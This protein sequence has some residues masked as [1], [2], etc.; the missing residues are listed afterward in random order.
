MSLKVPASAWISSGP[1]TS[2]ILACRLPSPR[3]AAASSSR[4]SGLV[5][6][7]ATATPRR[8]ARP[9]TATASRPSPP[10]IRWTFR[11]IGPLG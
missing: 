10:Q 6:E 4:A 1:P 9:S 5:T 7:R 11:S 2:L 8:P 3:A